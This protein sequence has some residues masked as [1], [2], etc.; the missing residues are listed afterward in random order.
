MD[1]GMNK[2]GIPNPIRP[3]PVRRKVSFFLRFIVF[4]MIALG[5]WSAL[6]Q[7]EPKRIYIANDD[8]TDYMWKANEAA[9]RNAFLEMTDYYLDQIDATQ[10]DPPEYQSRWNF[11]GTFW[12][13]TYEKNKTLEEFERLIGRVRDGHIH[14]PLNPLV[15]CYGGIPAEA[16]LRGMYYGGAIE[17]R[18]N[19]EFKTASPMENQT[20]PYGLG[21]LWAGSGVK[22]SWNGIC[23][24]A[25]KI[26]DPGNREFDIYWWLNADG[27]RILVKWNTFR[28]NASLGGYAEARSPATAINFVDT[29][30]SFKNKYPYRIIGIFGKGWDD[31]ETRTDEFMRVAM[32]QTNENRQ[33]IVS[34]EEDFFQD[35]EAAYGAD[36]PSLSTSFG[37][38]WDL[39]CASMAE[40]SAQVKRSVEKLRGAE[41]LATLASLHDP[42]FMDGRDIARDQAWMDLGLY[43][44]H[45]WTAD[46]SVSRADRAAWERRLAGEIAGYV[47][48]LY[49]DATQ[50]LA[51]MIRKSGAY[52]RFYA[53]N[54]LGWTR[55]DLADLP[56]LGTDPVHVVDLSTSQTVCSQIV[57]VDGE[58]RLRVLASDVPPVGYKVF[59]I[60]PGAREVYSDAATVTG[61]VLENEFYRITVAERGAITSLID[62][63]RGGKEFVRQIGGRW[64]NDLGSGS[65]SLH[66]ENLGPVSVTLVA[67]G[68]QPLAHT[69]RIT[70]IRGSRR[71]EIRNDINQNF[72][73]TFTWGFGFDLALPDVWHEEVGAVIRA[74]LPAAGGHYSPRQARYD[75]LTLNHFADISGEGVGVTLS[76]ADCYFMKL[77]ASTANLL[78]VLT[79]QISPLVGGQVDGVNL[80]IPGQGGETHFR[81][82]F[83]MQCH[84]AFDSAAAM[85]FALEHQN[86]LITSLITGGDA[87]PETLFSLVGISNPDALLW[88]LKPAEEGIG[89]GIVV[90]V[91]NQRWESTSSTL[92]LNQAPV[93]GASRLTHLESPLESM[94]CSDRRLS[95]TLAP[96]QMK[97]YL[98]SL[99]GGVDFVPPAV[100]SILRVGPSPT[101][102]EEV[103]FRVTFSEDVTGVDPSDFRLIKTETIQGGSILSVTRERDD[104]YQVRVNT[105]T[106]NGSIHLI[107]LDDDS[108]ED[109]AGNPLGG[110]GTENGNYSMGQETVLDRTMPDVILHS[111]ASNP[112][113]LSPIPVT[114]AFSEPVNG[115]DV[116]GLVL[117]NATVA[118]FAGVGANYSFN[119][120]PRQRGMLSVSIGM[121]A[122]QDA[123]GNPNSASAPLDRT[124]YGPAEEVWVSFVWSGPEIGSQILPFNTLSEATAVVLSGGTIKLVGSASS[125]E[126]IR[127]TRPDAFGIYRW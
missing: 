36:L 105:G 78:D 8:H 115:F 49:D 60:L 79:P 124:Y 18:Y 93:T 58:R 96:Q 42:T 104:V 110:I 11:D 45:D 95:D 80:G 87:Y 46:G 123:L 61:N 66:V 56:Y 101:R 35:F 10:D 39:L 73:E 40:V 57:T 48:T 26:N 3:L 75:W 14:V 27:S 55:S 72:S 121:G 102:A 92:V 2:H 16:I 99:A 7:A 17:R 1:G 83:A 85:R 67:D 59:E 126:R 90:R 88:A 76:N 13:W 24:C 100:F 70:L 4:I 94:M 33:I 32:E 63:T 107:L 47:D 54:P 77:G 21:A 97:T 112:T 71:I 44:E 53:L 89:S 25:T 122:A 86:P 113:I 31:L 81:Q 84:D 29:N 119:L 117:I 9:Y 41:A 38:E 127:I 109:L 51:G 19:L 82:R 12:L 125:R 37:N 43:W 91:W 114:A 120:V 6:A 15:V 118:N 62:K 103:N 68:S 98:L 116:N 69:S 50:A 64:M 23:N 111:T 108:I 20:L 28:G 65:G 22:Y 106:G 52:P 5:L 74:K 34:N 30:S